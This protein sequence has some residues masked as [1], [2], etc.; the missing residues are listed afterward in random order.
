M[1]IQFLEL[2][3][4]QIVQLPDKHAQMVLNIYFGGYS[5]SDFHWRKLFCF[6]HT[7]HLNSFQIFLE[8]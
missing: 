4:H 1:E 2:R 5:C 8:M 7:M 3:I 6:F